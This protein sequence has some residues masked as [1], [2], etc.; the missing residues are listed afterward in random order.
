MDSNEIIF[1]NQKHK[2][3]SIMQPFDCKDT[4]ADLHKQMNDSVE[5][6]DFFR[7][8]QSIYKNRINNDVNFLD[9][10]ENPEE[11]K[12]G[13]RYL[14]SRYN[15]LHNYVTELESDVDQSI[16]RIKQLKKNAFKQMFSAE[17]KLLSNMFNI[18]S[19]SKYLR[20]NFHD[21]QFVYIDN[22]VLLDERL[23][24]VE[25]VDVL[26]KMYTYLKHRF[27]ELQKYSLI[28]ESKIENCKNLMDEL[29]GKIEGEN[30]EDTFPFVKSPED[31]VGHSPEA[32]GRVAPSPKVKRQV[33]RSPE[34]EGRVVNSPEAEGRVGHSPKVKGRVA[35]S[36]KEDRVFLSSARKGRVVHS[37]VSYHRRTPVDV[38]QREVTS[39]EH[40]MRYTPLDEDDDSSFFENQR[41]S[42]EQGSPENEE[43]DYENE[44]DEEQTYYDNR[45]V[46]Q[47]PQRAVM[48]EAVAPKG[49]PPIPTHVVSTK[50]IAPE[51]K[52][53]IFKE[54]VKSYNNVGS[55]GYGKS[56]PRRNEFNKATI[57]PPV[58]SRVVK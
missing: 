28:Q 38:E 51:S 20:E 58:Q 32:E 53:K 23:D 55:T 52:V 47:K 49:L 45:S 27:A 37:P 7:F 17:K 43:Y 35:H 19:E 15:E 46:I 25:D 1:N 40:V 24:E 36:P 3:R 44:F 22:L 54:K 30:E 39:P 8:S 42:P 13:F 33:V 31:R 26:K 5:Y 56:K 29:F 18:S 57:L 16:H 11:I 48:P 14:Q 10:M 12:S 9:I 6:T 4:W 34:A 2:Q 21:H 41:A 50:R